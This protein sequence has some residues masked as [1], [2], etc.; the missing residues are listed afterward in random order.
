M[1]IFVMILSF[2]S[3][4]SHKALAVLSKR[5]IYNVLIHVEPCIGR[6]GPNNQE[7]AVIWQDRWSCVS[8]AGRPRGD[9]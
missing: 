4:R 7:V 3:E 2:V 5:E 8:L 1:S 6:L 9:A